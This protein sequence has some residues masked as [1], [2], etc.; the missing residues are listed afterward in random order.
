MEASFA[1]AVAA[2]D[3]ND[4]Q[5]VVTVSPALLAAAS[6]VGAARA[7][8][9]PVG[10]VVQDLYGKAVVETGAM[11]DKLGKATS[12]LESTVLRSANAVAIIHSRFADALSEIGVERE[13][14]T[15]IRNWT[16]I[17]GPNADN[18]TSVVR[19]R[20]GWKPDEV[21]VMHAGNMG[22]KQGLENVVAAAKLASS[23]P[24]GA[25]RVR[26]VLV[27]DGNQ[28]RI[29]TQM[30]AGIP[31]IDLVEPLEADDFPAVLAAADIL[32]VNERP[33][34]CD[35][36]VPS[37]LTSYFIAGKPIIAATD[38]AS[39]SADELRAAGAGLTVA[40]GQPQA[41][42]DAVCK[43][44]ADAD[45]KQRLGLHGEKYA[46]E[47]LSALSAIESYERWCFDMLRH[48]QRQIAS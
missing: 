20:F 29:L 19:A 4:P 46:R 9:V 11:G 40:P 33:G 5:V 1:R 31:A 43:I 18:D 39:G 25:R 28:R 38:P 34:V 2:G 10:V 14:L 22:V 26:F 37:K 3:W 32:L 30:A 45:A 41:L 12:R 15:V 13:K 48:E 44:D 7:R 36:A 17:S 35:M 23:V 42:L 8:R 16:H 21:I 6:V 24:D 47:V 27:G